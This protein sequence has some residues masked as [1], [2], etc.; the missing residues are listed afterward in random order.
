MRMAQREVINKMGGLIGRENRQGNDLRTNREVTYGQI[1]IR[2]FE[3]V[4]IFKTLATTNRLAD[5]PNTDQ[6]TDLN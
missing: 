6:Q 2:N 5:I 3:D 1:V 4:N